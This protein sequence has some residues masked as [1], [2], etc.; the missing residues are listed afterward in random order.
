MISWRWA[1]VVGK[2]VLHELGCCSRAR[3]H[4]TRLKMHMQGW[5]VGAGMGLVH[6]FP[7]R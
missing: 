2:S 7:G 1:S 5:G 6:C 3:E 4:A